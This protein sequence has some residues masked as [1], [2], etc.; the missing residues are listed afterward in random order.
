MGAIDD[1]TGRLLFGT[2]RDEEDSAGYLQLVRDI[3]R[4]H[5]LPEAIYR[6]RHGSLEPPSR[7][8]PPPDLAVADRSKPTHV[9]RALGELSIGSIAAGSP[10]AKGRI[11]RAWG[12]AQGRL[13]IELRLAGAVDRSSAEPVLVDFLAR[14]N[15]RFAIAAAD[16]ESAWR[17]ITDDIDLDAVC[18][19]RYDRVIAN[20]A[21][22]RIGGLVLDLP[23]QRGGRS[24]AG[25]RVEVRLELDGHI[26]VADGPRVL[27]RVE[28]DID[29]GRLRDLERERFSL[30]DVRTSQIATAPGYPPARDHPWR[31]ATPGSKL[32]AI[33][34]EERGLTDPRTS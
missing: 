26:V 15:A 23:R 31:R 22:V 19:F 20:D 13:V 27:H 25:K 10:Q 33:R 28:T 30:K 8:Q 2:F 32:E 34:R 6:D 12:T 21:T 4:A 17:P 11:E 1:A 7:R 18:A 9:G 14:F 3:A 16:P 5:G 29:P 24:L